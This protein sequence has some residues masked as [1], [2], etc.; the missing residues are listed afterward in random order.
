[1]RSRAKSPQPHQ[2]A[3]LRALLAEAQ[4]LG[5]LDDGSTIELSAR[6]PGKLLA[7]RNDRLVLG[8][9]QSYSSLRCSCL[10]F[11]TTSE[12]GSCDAKGRSI[13]PRHW[14][15][16]SIELV[17][18]VSTAAFVRIFGCRP[19]DDGARYCGGRPLA[20]THRD[21]SRPDWRRLIKSPG[22][23]LFSSAD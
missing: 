4:S 2:K 21:Q 6:V 3:R 15:F 1:M 18:A 5:Y 12:N 16:D 14:K 19:R 9:T 17:T 10:L 11:R 13:P 8:Q 22:Q 23:R 7:A 20:L